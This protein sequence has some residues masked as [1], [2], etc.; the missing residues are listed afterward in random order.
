MS[1]TEL[2][3]AFKGSTVSEDRWVLERSSFRNKVAVAFPNTRVVFEFSGVVD[4][5]QKGAVPASSSL[6]AFAVIHPVKASP[7]TPFRRPPD[8]VH[9][10]Y[11][12]RLHDQYEAALRKRNVK[13]E[14][15]A[16]NHPGLGY[17]LWEKCSSGRDG[18]L[19]FVYWSSTSLEGVFAL[20]PEALVGDDIEC[21]RKAARIKTRAWPERRCGNDRLRP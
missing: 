16:H 1:V 15:Q 18:A 4:E 13:H 5:H 10:R 11:L 14:A 3:K 9:Y 8:S 7:E 12:K 2:R 21:E 20:A 6:V 17:L 19:T